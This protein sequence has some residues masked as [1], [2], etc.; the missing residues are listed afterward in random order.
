LEA[1]Q[2]M[3]RQIDGAAEGVDE[4]PQPGLQSGP[5]EAGSWVTSFRESPFRDVH[6]G[7]SLAIVR[8]LQGNLN[9]GMPIPRTS[10]LFFHVEI[11][12]D[13]LMSPLYIYLQ[14]LDIDRYGLL[15]LRRATALLL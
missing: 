6:Q 9:H 8:D 13:I 11:Y 7:K 12:K 5:T 3:E 14:K 10:L 1:L 4:P 15:L 2:A